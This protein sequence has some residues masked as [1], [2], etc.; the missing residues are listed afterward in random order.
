[1]FSRALRLP[2]RDG[3]PPRQTSG[4]EHCSL[5]VEDLGKIG[6]DPVE[7]NSLEVEDRAL[8]TGAHR[9]YE[10]Q[11]ARCDDCSYLDVDGDDCASN[12]GRD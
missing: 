3:W 7:I 9:H 10:K 2:R 8:P 5:S 4:V 12:R 11:I 6:S 1:M